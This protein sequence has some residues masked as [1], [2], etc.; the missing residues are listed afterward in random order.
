M[1]SP[2]YSLIAAESFLL[3]FSFVFFFMVCP[4]RTIHINYYLHSKITAVLYKALMSK[5]MYQK[6][7]KHLTCIVRK[8]KG[9]E[10]SSIGMFAL[11]FFFCYVTL[12]F[13]YSLFI[14]PVSLLRYCYQLFYS[15]LDFDGVFG[16]L[17]K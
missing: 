2:L 11:V 12:M 16:E 15:G 6:T 7:D 8:V 4:G 9:S 3:N 13:P 1:S 5:Y 10:F 14:I 17:S